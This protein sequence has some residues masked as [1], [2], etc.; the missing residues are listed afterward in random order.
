MSLAVAMKCVGEPMQQ[1]AQVLEK[2][3]SLRMTS[4]S[5]IITYAKGIAGCNSTSGSISQR[6]MQTAPSTLDMQKHLENLPMWRRMC[7]PQQVVYL[8]LLDVGTRCHIECSI[9]FWHAEFA[10]DGISFDW[11]CFVW[12]STTR[13]HAPSVSH[14]MHNLFQTNSSQ[15]RME[16]Q[17]KE[18]NN[19]WTSH[20]AVAMHRKSLAFLFATIFS[21]GKRWPLAKNAL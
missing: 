15:H 5:E 11:R 19:N 6:D 21:L 3:N 17:E 2:Q 9:N 14:G 18:N 1:A 8:L 12:C 20:E 7:G 16:C 10:F 4:G 13:L